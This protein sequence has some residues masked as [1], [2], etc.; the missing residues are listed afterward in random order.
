M[1]RNLKV[2]I[3]AAMALAAFG[4]LSATAHAAEEKFHCSVEP[5]TL[6]LGPDET[7]GTTTAHH[8][9]VVKG[10]TAAGAEAS[11]SFTCNQLT[12]HATSATKTATEL[13]FT[14]LKYENSLGEQKCKVGASETVEVNFT[15]CDY[16]FTSTGGSTVT[17]SQVHVLCITAGDAIDISIKGTLCLQVTPFT[18]NGIGYHDSN[19]G[20]AKKIV[21]A[22]AKVTIPKEAVHLKNIGNVNCA[23]LGLSVIHHAEYTTGNT[24]VR[25]ET[26]SATPVTA[27]AWFE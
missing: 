20:G 26:D 19:I 4:A 12:G 14:S 1:I 17:G 27:E 2:L 23:A 18:A 25:A 24:L 6:T 5:C 13:T 7:A 8:V 10:T 9:F 22:T 3:A 16:K 21:T 15:S 11:V